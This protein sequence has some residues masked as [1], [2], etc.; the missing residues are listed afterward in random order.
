LPLLRQTKVSYVQLH[1]EIERV[2]MYNPEPYGPLQSF[3]PSA[4]LNGLDMLARAIDHT[5]PMH[6]SGQY[7]DGY[8]LGSTSQLFQPEA[9]LPA[10]FTTRTWL[11]AQCDL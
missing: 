5:H 1:I 10:A 9:M 11:E 6:T 4:E 2:N 7:G 8:L 3:G